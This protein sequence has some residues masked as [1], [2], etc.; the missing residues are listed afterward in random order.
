M[1]S[2]P[3][4]YAIRSSILACP[5]LPSIL[6]L[7]LSVPPSPSLALGLFHLPLSTL[8]RKSPPFHSLNIW[9]LHIYTWSNLYGISDLGFLLCSRPTKA[10]VYV[11]SPRVILKSQIQHIQNWPLHFPKPGY[12]LAFSQWM[13]PASIQ[14]HSGNLGPI[15][16]PLPPLL[17][18]WV[19]YQVQDH[20]IYLSLS[21]LLLTPRDLGQGKNNKS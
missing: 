7:T 8:S 14:L 20:W 19:H 18:Y 11:I 17:L 4:L 5:L 9:K 10:M 12:P 6:S 1:P 16:T 2:V 13:T 15:W 21:S 3:S